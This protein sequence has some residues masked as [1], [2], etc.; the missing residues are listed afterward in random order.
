MSKVIETTAIERKYLLCEVRLAFRKI[1]FKHWLNRI[2]RFA[3][4]ELNMI[5]FCIRVVVV[6]VNSTHIF[7]HVS[8]FIIVLAPINF[9]SLG[10]EAFVIHKYVSIYVL[11]PRMYDVCDLSYNSTSI[12]AVNDSN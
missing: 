8:D 2:I 10:S 1:K 3:A 7:A 4:D 9:R 6:V 5:F 11:R 12:I